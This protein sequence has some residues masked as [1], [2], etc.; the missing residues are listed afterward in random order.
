MLLSRWQRCEAA[1]Q[2]LRSINSHVVPLAKYARSKLLERRRRLKSDSVGLFR[3]REY[4]LEHL[5]NDGVIQPLDAETAGLVAWFIL[6]VVVFMQCRDTLER[7]SKS[8]A[9]SREV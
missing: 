5:R 4:V 7:L 1:P 2:S 9:L 6:A 8:F 3:E